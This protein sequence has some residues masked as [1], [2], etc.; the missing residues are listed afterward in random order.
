MCAC[1]CASMYKAGVPSHRFR[2]DMIHDGF[3]G[4][5]DT[6]GLYGVLQL[7]GVFPIFWLPPRQ[8]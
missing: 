2:V 7:V 4:M 5:G 6:I 8:P 3:S 1:A